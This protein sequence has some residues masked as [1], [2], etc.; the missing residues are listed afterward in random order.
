VASERRKWPLDELLK[1][2]HAPGTARVNL[3]IALDSAWAHYAQEERKHTEQAKKAVQ[4]AAHLRKRITETL[5]AIETMKRY[6]DDVH[7]LVQ[8]V[9]RGVIE[10][11]NSR[12]IILAGRTPDPPLNPSISD[13]ELVFPLLAGSVAVINLEILIRAMELQL[14]RIYRQRGRGRPADQGTHAVMFYAVNFFD[15]HSQVRPSHDMNNPVRQ[16]AK[17]FFEIVSGG[18]IEARAPNWAIRLAVNAALEKNRA[19]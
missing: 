6:D 1:L 13:A 11:A 4:A 14:R 12:E 15:T 8:P 10:V 7:I 2:A 18:T 17:R 19:K 5:K 16:F 3:Q 9:G